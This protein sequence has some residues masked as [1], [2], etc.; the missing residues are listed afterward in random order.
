MTER[1]QINHF[2]GLAMQAYISSQNLAHNWDNED[3]A[4][5]AK[6]SYAMAC[7]MIDQRDDLYEGDVI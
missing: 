1:E 3:L 7:A 5:I 2:A 6:F 4:G